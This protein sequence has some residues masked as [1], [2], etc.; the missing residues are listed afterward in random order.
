M[1]P[2]ITQ[3]NVHLFI[4][5]TISK[6]FAFICQ[7]EHVSPQQAIIKFY[8]TRTIRLLGQED[9]KLWHLG[10]I[11]LYEMYQEEQNGN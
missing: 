8:I 4:P 2:E 1:I 5:Y 11:A 10:W 7:N 9:T 3:K 6:I